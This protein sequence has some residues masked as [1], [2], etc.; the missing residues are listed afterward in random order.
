MNDLMTVILVE[1]TQTVR[2][3][4]VDALNS[5]YVGQVY[6]H[7]IPDWP[8]AQRVLPEMIESAHLVLSDIN[9]KGEKPGDEDY[10]HTEFDGLR[11]FGLAR[12][13]NSSIPII[14]YTAFPLAQHALDQ[15]DQPDG[16]VWVIRKSGVEDLDACAD[17]LASAAENLIWNLPL[18]KRE[19]AFERLTQGDSTILS[20]S[21]GKGL[22][23][24]KS[25]LTVLA[26]RTM[27]PKSLKQ[28]V[29]CGNLAKF[30]PGR[31]F[32]FFLLARM[33][34]PRDYLWVTGGESFSIAPP[35]SRIV[36]ERS[37]WEQLLHAMP[38][39]FDQNR[40]N[41]RLGWSSSVEDAN[42][43]FAGARH[44]LMPRTAAKLEAC[45]KAA[46]QLSWIA[47][48][49]EQRFDSTCAAYIAEHAGE[50]SELLRRDWQSMLSKLFTG[51][52]FTNQLLQFP[53]VAEWEQIAQSL[54]YVCVSSAKHSK[55]TPKIRLLISKSANIGG[56]EL[57]ITVSDDG[58]GIQEFA[59]AFLPSSFARPT[60]D[61]G[62]NHKLQLA[63]GR[64]WGYC[65]W[66]IV[67]KRHGD[68][69]VR[70]HNA[71]RADD[72][73]NE[74]T[75]RLSD[76]VQKLR[77]ATSGTLH[78]LTFGCPTPVDGEFRDEVMDLRFIG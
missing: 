18:Q 3:D 17:R 52:A 32:K 42:T 46:R 64:L 58:S 12:K 9:L 31:S 4:T 29:L 65:D 34:K 55:T 20:E 53:F 24:W 72:D 56:P 44:V 49:D 50:V 54:N 71:F 48:Y 8:V 28:S 63:Q 47:Q 13:H 70:F 73:G 74:V 35:K 16:P 67:S 41:W 69:D 10:T 60:E 6:V 59:G 57:T 61:L 7:Q 38:R 76:E 43:E 22:P 77:N 78:V 45:L 39:E 30:L 26:A 21:A 19:I 23:S 14:L 51:S 1:D 5:R 75:L 33:L 40:I 37:A 62:R 36:G 66:H 25:I 68:A 27:R 11:V 15:F 2:R